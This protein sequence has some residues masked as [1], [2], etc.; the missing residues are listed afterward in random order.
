[1]CLNVFDDELKHFANINVVMIHDLNIFR[2][3]EID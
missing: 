3:V 1:M 2:N